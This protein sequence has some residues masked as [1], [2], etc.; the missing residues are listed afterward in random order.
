[1]EHHARKYAKS[2]IINFFSTHII[3][4]LLSK[5]GTSKSKEYGKRKGNYEYSSLREEGG[6]EAKEEKKRQANYESFINRTVC[7]QN[8]NIY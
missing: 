6:E 8:I 5:E 7:M 4:Y 1:V 2:N 3:I